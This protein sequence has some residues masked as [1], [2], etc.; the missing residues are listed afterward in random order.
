MDKTYND[1]M[2]I[3]NRTKKFDSNEKS[4]PRPPRETRVVREIDEETDD[5]EIKDEEVLEKPKTSLFDGKDAITKYL[6]TKKEKPKSKTSKT[7]TKTT[8]KT[9]KKDSAKTKKTT[10][11][12]TKSKTAKAPKTEK[13][14]QKEV[15]KAETKKASVKDLAD[16][17]RIIKDKKV[18]KPTKQAPVIDMNDPRVIELYKALNDTLLAGGTDVSEYLGE[19]NPVTAKSLSDLQNKKKVESEK[20]T[21][22]REQE[23][24]E[25]LFT[26]SFVN[27]ESDN[28]E[29]SDDK[30]QEVL[31]NN[32]EKNQEFVLENNESDETNTSEN[33]EDAPQNNEQS[34]SVSYSNRFDR[35]LEE[36]NNRN[37]ELDQKIADYYKRKQQKIDDYNKSE[38]DEEDESFESYKDSYENKKHDYEDIFN[39]QIETRDDDEKENEVVEDIHNETETEEPSFRDLYNSLNSED[40]DPYADIRYVTPNSEKL[41]ADYE[42]IVTQD[43]VASKPSDNADEDEKENANNTDA[44]QNSL[45]RF[46]ESKEDTNTNTKQT[47]EDDELVENEVGQIEN[48]SKESDSENNDKVYDLSDDDSDLDDYIVSSNIPVESDSDDDSVMV[49]DQDEL[50]ESQIDVLGREFKP[51]SPKSQEENKDENSDAISKEE[52]Y[53]EMARLQEN[54]L[55]QLKGEKE[56]QVEPVKQSESDTLNKALD[57]IS[58][59]TTTKSEPTVQTQAVENSHDNSKAENVANELIEDINNQFENN[60]ETQS[61]TTSPVEE[62]ITPETL[63]PL[64][65]ETKTLCNALGIEPEKT[66]TETEK[67]EESL[68]NPEVALNEKDIEYLVDSEKTKAEK[69][70][71]F[72]LSDEDKKSRPETDEY[73]SV[74]DEKGKEMGDLNLNKD[75]ANAVSTEQQVKETKKAPTKTDDMEVIYT[76]FG[77]EKKKV[78]KEKEN[79]KVLF[80]A[81]ECQPFIATGG[82]GD[83]AG[84]LPK[85]IAKLDGIDIRVILPLYGKIKAE[86]GDKLEY[87][88]NFTVHLSWR[89]EYCGLF[90]YTKDG[91]TYYF[92]DNERYFKRDGIYGFYDDGERFA[93]FCKAVVESLPMLNFFPDIIH[94]NDWESALVSTYIKTGNWSDFRYYK[95]KNIYTIHNVEYQGIYG[96]ENLK[97]LFG[98][99]PRFK[100]DLEY[101]S[102]IN[103][104]KAA[105]QY[106][107]KFTTVSDSYCDN[108][109]QPYCSRGLHHIV[110]RNEYKLSG[111]LNGIDYDFYNPATDSVIFKNY[112]V[113][114]LEN[115]VLNKK[116]WQDELGLPVDGRTPMIAVV[117][118][119]VS[120]KGIDLLTKVLEDVLQ[121]DIQF[122]VVGTGD[123]R[124]TDYFKYLENKY[125][126]KVRALVDKYS[127]ESARR[128]YAASDIFVMPSKIEPCGI[129]QMIA[130]RYGSVPIVREV[131]GLKDTIKDFGCVDGGNG[132]TFA[133][134]NPNDLLSQ[135]NRAINDYKDENGWKNKMRIVMT[136]DFSWDKSAKK[137]L[138]L[139]KSLIN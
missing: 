126:T 35:D 51:E 29:V 111:I 64:E 129:S 19:D 52:F 27:D 71:Y 136:T 95:I 127:N 6:N 62:T 45:D 18:V 3:V 128:A 132:Y 125:P 138:D 115:K 74:Y 41:D 122:V 113:D 105:I 33:T 139:Y 73:M 123:S 96:M 92:V 4:V 90:K 119:L 85:A 117:S 53:N 59:L 55:N 124:Y 12:T 14:P 24:Y 80:V 2:D 88:G 58:N 34:E 31:K 36:F 11:T 104:T 57:I 93:Y 22:N 89:Q 81:S 102:D 103:L 91:V 17:I 121:K 25:K 9:T 101:N 137:Y 67:T 75:I 94:C 44:W 65:N 21:L 70:N 99:D 5:T 60:E 118:R 32:D 47:F 68:L 108:L 84:S 23:E 72:Y 42:N 1:L 7:E 40:D 50:P 97:D 79:M 26:G 63:N 130:S 131:G 82:L 56:Q 69:P 109:K 133:N 28:G 134:Y 54:L 43:D 86:Y 78:E 15:S 110:I 61:E 107:D 135:I 120:H 39:G 8:K 106:S 13:A 100:N 49:L 112:D 114:T 83:V 48:Y 10:K 37:Q 87:I 38:N 46:E 20:E 76:I 98:I 77:V 66:E 116:I 30:L 16:K